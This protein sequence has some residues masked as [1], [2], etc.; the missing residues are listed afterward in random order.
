MYAHFGNLAHFVDS[1]DDHD[2]SDDRD[3][4]LQAIALSAFQ[5]KCV[6]FTFY[7]AS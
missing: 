2:K 7:D 5:N 4:K 3:G 6:Y 1:G